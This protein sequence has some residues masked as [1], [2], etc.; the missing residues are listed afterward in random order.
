VPGGGRKLLQIELNDIDLSLR[1]MLRGF[2]LKVGKTT[3]KIFRTLR[4]ISLAWRSSRFSRSSVFSFA[5]TSDRTLGERPMSRS[6]LVNHPRITGVNKDWQRR[7]SDIAA[8]SK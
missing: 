1:G 2:G 3:P 4:R 8:S 7:R 6:A 5:A